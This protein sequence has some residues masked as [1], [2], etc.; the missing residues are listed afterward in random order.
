MTV[1]CPSIVN[2]LAYVLEAYTL[3]LKIEMIHLN[4]SNATHTMRFAYMFNYL[5]TCIVVPSADIFANSLNPDPNRVNIPSEIL[6]ECH[7]DW[8]S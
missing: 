4:S 7:S 2:I 5:P 6:L 1:K 3:C 8:I